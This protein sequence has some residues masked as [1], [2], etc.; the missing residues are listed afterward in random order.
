M[1]SLKAKIYSS[2][3]IIRPKIIFL[4]VLV[5]ML[6]LCVFGRYSWYTYRHLTD[7]QSHESR[8]FELVGVIK[9]LDEVLTMST[10]MVAAIIANPRFLSGGLR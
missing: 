4:S 1:A 7:A 10:H 8:I 3:L 9:H 2:K 5:L 6:I